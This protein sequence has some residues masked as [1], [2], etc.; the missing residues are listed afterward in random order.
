MCETRV[1]IRE[2]GRERERGTRG[3]GNGKGERGAMRRMV[4]AGMG[5]AVMVVVSVAGIVARGGEGPALG[6]TD[7]RWGPPKRGHPG[8]VD[9]G[10]D[11]SLEG[12]A[13]WPARLP[14]LVIHAGPHKTGTTSLQYFLAQHGGWLSSQV[15]VFAAVPWVD[16]GAGRGPFPAARRDR[17]PSQAFAKWNAHLANT[18]IKRWNGGDQ[19][20]GNPNFQGDE[21][22]KVASDTRAALRLWASGSVPGV[23]AAVI[24]AEDFSLLGSDGW[25]ALAREF[26]RD[27]DVRVVVVHR[28]P[29]DRL[30]S[31][32]FQS[33]RTSSDPV[34][35]LAFLGMRRVDP[36]PRDPAF[37]VG[38]VDRVE[39]AGLKVH[40]VSYERAKACGGAAGVASF[41]VCNASLGLEGGAWTKCDAAIQEKV[42]DDGKVKNVSP[43]ETSIPLVL[44]LREVWERERMLGRRRCKDTFDITAAN[45]KIDA[46]AA[47]MP[48]QCVDVDKLYAEADQAFFDRARALEPPSGD[49]CEGARGTPQRICMLGEFRRPQL[50]AIE[51]LLVEL[52]LCN[53]LPDADDRPRL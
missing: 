23:E 30:Q 46:L 47:A 21:S 35:F 44:R 8:A 11:G 10:L 49:E 3:R 12:P 41:V 39:S 19:Q 16:G 32:W 52:A 15:G 34:D 48:T 28:H 26:T 40:G 43:P 20:P 29:V 45:P 27:W 24:S 50:E 53:D 4:A 9:S 37:D 38:L 33:Q 17:G 51:A 31:V 18:E 7:R 13:T 5:L 2:R 22:V 1:A 14:V 42:A 36:D 25:E 6:M